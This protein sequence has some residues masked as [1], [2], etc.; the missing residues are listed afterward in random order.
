M[1]RSKVANAFAALDAY[2]RRS[3]APKIADLFAADPQRFDRFHARFDDLLYDFSKHR[4]DAETLRLLLDL[5]RAAEVEPR[6]EAL[7]EGDPVNITERRAALHM[8]L[9][10]LSGAPMRAAG[11]DV[12]AMVEAEREKLLAFAEA[13]RSGAIR[14]ANGARF[15]DIVNFGIGGSDLGPAM[16]ARALSPFI[17][18]HLRLHFVANVDG[19]DFADTMRNTP[20]ETTL[21]IVCSKTFTTLETMTN[22]ATARAYVAERLGPDAIASH[23]CAVS[24]QLDRIAAFGVRSDRVFGFW[25]WVGGR[26]SIW[27]SIGLS[28]AIGVGRD[29]F[30][31]FLRGGEDIDRH[32]REAPL[33][34]NIPVLMALIGVLN[35]NVF[36]YATQAVIPYD[37]RLARFP[38]YLQQLDMESNGKSVDLSGARVAYETSPVVWGE[39]GTNGQHAFFQLLHQGTEI[40]PVDFLVA[41]KPT[42]AD[43]THHRI[44]FANCLAQ[45]QALMQGRP[46]EAVSAQLAAQGLSPDA[47][48]ALAPHKVFDGDRPSSTFLYTALTPRTLGRL[49]ALYE[50]KIFV[51]GVIWDINSFDQWG[52]ELGKELAQKLAPIVGDDS[53]STEALDASTA[54]LVQAAR[55][56]RAGA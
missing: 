7:F 46:L 38:A 20:V 30:E 31:A 5:G 18:D 4:L 50:H 40:V 41:A 44:L 34:R 35:R 39:P 11:E 6:R 14:A 51:Q 27:S 54:G 55:A 52:V 15:T 42:A 12:A 28:L 56:R 1:D 16:A 22:A 2:A 9:R 21:F 48:A 47:I 36:G 3:G 13:V 19:A 23:F 29:N 25:D 10:N 8:A 37:Q 24:T 17:A 49:I 53:A 43:E 26:Y 45:S 33:E 32:F